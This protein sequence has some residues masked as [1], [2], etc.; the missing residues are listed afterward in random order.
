MADKKQKAAIE[1]LAQIQE[2][3]QGYALNPK[4]ADAKTAANLAEEAA[5]LALELLQAKEE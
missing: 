3:A 1:R 5:S 2:T 4:Q